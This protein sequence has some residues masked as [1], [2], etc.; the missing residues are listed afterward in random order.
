MLLFPFGQCVRLRTDLTNTRY[1]LGMLASY[2]VG[3][4]S[5]DVLHVTLRYFALRAS[6]PPAILAMA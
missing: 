5:W 4:E 3:R 2:P 1:A 6:F